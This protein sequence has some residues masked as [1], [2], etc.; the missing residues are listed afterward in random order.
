MSEKPERPQ[1]RRGVR[2]LRALLDDPDH[3]E[4]AFEVTDALDPD[5]PIRNLRRLLSSRDG[6]RIYEERPSLLDALCDRE[7]LAGMPEGSLGRAYL[8]HI[9]RHGLEPGKLIEISRA[10]RR[11]DAEPGLAWID[12]RGLLAHDLWHVLTGYG[13]D[14][15]GEAALLWFG[16]AQSGGRSTRVLAVGAT[17]RIVQIVGLPWLRYIYRAWRSG[18]RAVFLLALPYEEMLARPLAEA[19]ERARIEPPERVH[20]DGVQASESYGELAA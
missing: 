20:P 7:R 5:R 16:V 14:G 1:W 15:L 9:D 2:A 19:R 3:T 6:R 8:A 4:H 12:E 10:R 17:L 11:E 13:A 18:R